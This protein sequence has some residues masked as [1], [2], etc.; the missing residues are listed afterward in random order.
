M[1]LLT[2]F[3]AGLLIGCTSTPRP[4]DA[5]DDYIA[6]T[7]LATVDKIKPNYRD[8]WGVLTDRYI[9]Y[10][11]RKQFYLL[12]FASRCPALSNRLMMVPDQRFEHAIRPGID[13]IRGC[14][15]EA[16]YGVTPE[17]VLELQ[18]LGTPPGTT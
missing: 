11:S 3:V 17:Q 1:R 4:P 15:I 13:T 16:M 18:N 14:M 8:K 12:G 10:E 9:I 5:V 7:Q 6:T 2:L